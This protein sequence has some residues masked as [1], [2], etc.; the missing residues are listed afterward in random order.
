MD[1]LY[2]YYYYLQTGYP[3]ST[4]TNNNNNNS[5]QCLR[6]CLHEKGSTGMKVHPI[7]LINAEQSQAAAKHKNQ[8]N[9]FS[10]ESTCRLL[11]STLTIAIY[12]YST[13]F[14]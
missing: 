9:I 12:Y 2:Y 1:A 7:H 10:C 8:A 11:S 14:S 3:R 5:W 4:H 13:A 6:C